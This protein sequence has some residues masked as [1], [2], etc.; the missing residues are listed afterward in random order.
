M[1][2]GFLEKEKLIFILIASKTELSEFRFV[3]MEPQ[4]VF[5]VDEFTHYIYSTYSLLLFPDSGFLLT[6]DKTNLG[7]LGTLMYSPI[8]DLVI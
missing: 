4:D 7:F 1:S 6:A 5:S 3:A 8:C 2:E